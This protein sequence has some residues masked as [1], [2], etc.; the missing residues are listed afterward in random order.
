MVEFELG[1]QTYRAGKLSAFKQFHV[2]RRIAPIIPTLIPVFVKIAKD[3][4]ATE[5]LNGLA[6]VMT[7]FADGIANMTDETS[8]Y[9]LSTCLSVIQR[10]HANGW[11]SV[12]NVQGNSC[13]FDDMDLGVLIQLVVRVVQDS[14]GPFISGLLMSQPSG[15]TSTQNG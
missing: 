6:E 11:A 12:W 10:K 7:P 14:L 9:V 5:D 15:P 1:G 3:G 13:M 2:S 4:G 8:E